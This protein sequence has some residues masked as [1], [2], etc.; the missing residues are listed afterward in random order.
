MKLGIGNGRS[1]RKSTLTQWWQYR[2]SKWPLYG[3]SAENENEEKY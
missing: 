1:R 3:E 2:K